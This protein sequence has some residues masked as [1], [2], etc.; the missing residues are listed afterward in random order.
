MGPI[1]LA[2][3]GAGDRGS[4]YGGYALLHPDRARVVAVAEPRS[5]R[6]D[7]FARVHGLG[8]DACFD[9]WRPLLAGPRRADAVIVATQDALHEGPACAFLE[10]GWNV[11]LEKPMAPSEQGCRSIAEA[12]H[13]GGGLFVLCHVLRYTAYTRGL[14]RLLAE[15]RIGEL[16]S[17]QR[18]E[19]VGW[20]HHAH[21]YVRGNWRREGESC[22][23]LLA[24]SCHDLDWIRHVLGRPCRQ[25]SSFGSLRHFRKDAR[26]R[27]AAERCLDCSLEGSC[28]Y[29]A[30]KIYLGRVDR[31]DT[32]WPTRVLVE[33]AVTVETVTA[34]L[35]HGPYGR[36]VYACDNDVVDHQVVNMAFDDGLTAAFTMTA[37]TS[38]RSRETRLFGSHGEIR[39]D[40]RKIWL[41]DFRTDEESLHDF[42]P[43][44]PAGMANHDGGDHALM[45]AFV[46]AVASDD[47]EAILSGVRE[48]LESHLMV[49]AAERAR[50][51]GCV[52]EL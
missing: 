34:A 44:G 26:P 48:S 27:G 6:R 30:R 38:H 31:G 20:W 32:G 36:C 47:G 29:S 22:S 10:A 2:V 40:G 52:V 50:R 1:R 11:L 9:D 35:R 42:P 17:L 5:T 24:K 25:I 14:K 41:H 19:P 12:A 7:A 49:F 39:G 21:S 18:L 37:F 28:P 8:A 46:Q 15:G 33:G 16:V 45:T 51:E 3:V 23:M 4:R 13:R 43:D